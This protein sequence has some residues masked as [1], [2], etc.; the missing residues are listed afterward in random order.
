MP[1]SSGAAAAVNWL[2]GSKL[3]EYAKIISDRTGA[4]QAFVWILLLGAVVSL[5]EMATVIT[6]SALGNVRLAVNTLLGGVATTS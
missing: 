6:A 4:E 3:A 2:V 5:P 1:Q